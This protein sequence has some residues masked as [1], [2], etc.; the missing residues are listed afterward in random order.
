M[1]APIQVVA[2]RGHGT[3][4]WMC[5][6]L[7]TPT[8][9]GIVTAESVPSWSDAIDA[10]LE[11][12]RD[13]HPEVVWAAGGSMYRETYCRTHGVPRAECSPVHAE[14]AVVPEVAA[15]RCEHCWHPVAE[16]YG[17]WCR[18]V[19]GAIKANGAKR[20]CCCEG[21]DSAESSG[22]LQITNNPIQTAH[23]TSREGC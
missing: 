6:V 9:Q 4:L 7:H 1:S 23:N 8:T 14:R 21:A 5:S 2:Q 16:H 13:H 20:I 11:H 17:R 15:Q 22:G 19:T 3:W 12:L 18:H 10:G